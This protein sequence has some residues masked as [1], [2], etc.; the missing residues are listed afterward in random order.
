MALSVAQA[1]TL[2]AKSVRGGENDDTIKADALDALTLAL[3]EL[4]RT[5]W[6]FNLTSESLT[7]SASVADYSV[8]T[9]YLKTY[10]ARWGTE[11]ALVFLPQRLDERIRPDQTVGS[12]THY[13]VF[14]WGSTNKLRLV[15]SPD[16]G[17]AGTL[18]THNYYRTV[19]VATAT[20]GNVD[21]PSIYQYYPVYRGK[22]IL[23]GDRNGPVARI[24]FWESKA[25]E[26]LI[27][28]KR[29]DQFHPDDIPR[30]HPF[31]LA[32]GAIPTD[33]AWRTIEDVYGF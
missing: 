25:R 3:D 20:G 30:F 22:G 7:A 19:T 14:P 33:H 5:T 1:R 21:L 26:L 11:R 8:A 27:R 15:P 13:N 9:N 4:N 12:P 17:E 28:M 16:S 10:S 23:L 29:F 6:N 32:R 24:N 18:I 31:D 2:I